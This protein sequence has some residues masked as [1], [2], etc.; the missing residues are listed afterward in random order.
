MRTSFPTI[1]L[2]LKNP[3]VAIGFCH[4]MRCDPI[5]VMSCAGMSIVRFVTCS[6]GT[7]GMDAS[8]ASYRPLCVC[9]FQPLVFNPSPICRLITRKSEYRVDCRSLSFCFS[10]SAICSLKIGNKLHVYQFTCQLKAVAD[11]ETDAR[12]RKA[13]AKVHW[14]LM[15]R[16]LTLVI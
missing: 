11:S 8:H 4:A 7:C 10:F 13:S 5:P 15:Y 9:A 6:S 16:L 1:L 3:N 2:K 12:R 14:G